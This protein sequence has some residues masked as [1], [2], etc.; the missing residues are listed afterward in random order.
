MGL[1]VV[2][3]LPS[4]AIVMPCKRIQVAATPVMVHI[5]MSLDMAMTT[6]TMAVTATAS[7]TSVSCRG[8]TVTYFLVGLVVVVLDSVS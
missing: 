4:L 3:I 8:V 5:L 1:V 2:E 7:S 6:I